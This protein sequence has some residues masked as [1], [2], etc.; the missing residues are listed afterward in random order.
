MP[1]N[2]FY[3]FSEG[4]IENFCRIDWDLI[5]QKML[6]VFVQFVHFR[7]I[8]RSNTADGGFAYI[9]FYYYGTD[10]GNDTG[11]GTGYSGFS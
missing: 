3:Y 6:S 7:C 11:T 4:D 9:L 5:R 1:L 2:W 8:C 10:N